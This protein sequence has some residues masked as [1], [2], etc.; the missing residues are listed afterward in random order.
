MGNVMTFSSKPRVAFNRPMTS[1]AISAEDSV[2]L[3]VEDDA[4]YARILLGIAR[5]K[6]FKGIVAGDYDHLPE[7]AFYMVGNTEEAIEK[8]KRI[9]SEAA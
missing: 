2:L 4:H 6:G 9:A 7:S 8:A 5:G 3:I 1:E